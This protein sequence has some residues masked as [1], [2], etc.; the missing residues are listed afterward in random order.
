MYLAK[1]NK[2]LPSESGMTCN[3]G[4]MFK[5]FCILRLRNQVYDD[6]IEIFAFKQ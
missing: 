4:Y 6:V 3:Q 5:G 2:V 1:L